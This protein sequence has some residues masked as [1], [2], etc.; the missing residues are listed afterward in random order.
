[1]PRKAL[2]EVVSRVKEAAEGYTVGDPSTEVD[3]G[4][5]VSRVQRDRVRAYIE[6]GIAEGA[7]LVTGGPEAP[8]ELDRGYYVKPTVFAD[9]VSSMTIAQEEI[10]GPVLSILAYDDDDD[11]V[12]IANDTPYGLSGA[13][14]SKDTGRASRVARRL[15]TG[16]V[17]ING[18]GALAIPFGGFKQSG[19]GREHGR[20]GL[21]EFVEWQAIT[22]PPSS[23][24]PIRERIW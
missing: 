13:I 5:L 6:R 4:P 23:P 3:L 8:S 1:V 7:R 19:I 15:R 20:F 2:D 21:E 16:M 22:N 9:V 11:A 10:F 17:K 18:A 14:W 24:L 12:R